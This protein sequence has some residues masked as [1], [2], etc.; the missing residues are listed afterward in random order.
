MITDRTQA[1]A[2]VGGDVFA[3]SRVGTTSSR[4]GFTGS[5][6]VST[7]VATDGVGTLNTG[8]A[9]VSVNRALVNIG[10]T[11][12]SGWVNAARGN[13]TFFGMGGR[14]SCSAVTVASPSISASADMGSVHVGA[15]TSLLGQHTHVLS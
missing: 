8:A 13:E 6:V 5:R 14:V 9:D 11:S 10:A 1:G 4:V 12:V 2:V 7:S 15:N 3:G